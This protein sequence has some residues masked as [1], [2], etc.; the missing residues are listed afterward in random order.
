MNVRIIS[1]I[2]KG[3]KLDAPDNNR[4]HPMSERVRNAL[5]N[6]IGSEI[7]DAAVLDAFAGTGAIG[8]EALSRGA[9]HV[10]FIERDRLAQKILAKNIATIGA[11]N[12]TS[13]IHATVGNWL[14]TYSGEYFD[15]I[16]ADPPYHDPQ[17]STI[18]KL[19]G[20]LKPGG[21]MVLSHP[22][23]GEEPT[24]NGVVVVDNRSYGNAFLT[25]YRRE[26]A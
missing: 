22:G 23:R 2:Y 15:I 10:T 13:I 8:L 24:K 18:E 20:L 25:F 12:T 3:R 9:R 11:K 1:G 6:S 7:E 17:F 5:F 19:L 21:L 14:T 4:T 26:Y 16:F